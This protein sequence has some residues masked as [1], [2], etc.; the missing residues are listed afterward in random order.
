MR[1]TTCDRARFLRA[2]AIVCVLAAAH[3]RDLSAQAPPVPTAPAQ[4]GP[5]VRRLTLEE[6]RQLALQ[7][8]Q[9]LM[10]ARLNVVEKGHATAAA[11]KDYLPKVLGAD[12]FFHF[13]DD[14]GSVVTF[15]TGARGILPVSARTIN[16]AVLNQDTNLATLFVAQP[17]TKLIAVHAATQVARADEGAAQAQLDKGTRDVLSGVTQAFH[18]L[19]G[20]QRIQ[21]ALE[22]QI[23]LLEQV[24]GTKPAP[25]LR[26][27]LLEARQGLVQV[28]GQVRELTQQFN[29]LLDLPACTVLDLIDPVP[30]ELSIHREEDA[31]R[32]ALACSPEVREAEQSIAKAEAAMKIAKM[33]CLPDVSVVAGYANQT[34]ASY[35]QPNIGYVGVTGSYTFWEWGKR[36]DIK[37]QRDMDI[38]LAHQNVRVV[39][40]KVQLDARK[41]YSAYDQSREELHLA[42]EMVQTRKEIAKAATGPAAAQAQAD[43]AKAELEYMKAEIAYRVAHAQLAGLIGGQ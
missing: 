40:D 26:V 25:Q 36:R 34:G 21:A 31:A 17:I 33:A 28:R 10:L 16:A 3:R 30:T 20:A 29:D 2:L 11:R 19:L 1:P 39:S 13:N 12:T 18:G 35:I 22:L 7:Q 9:S 23:R 43:A 42:G 14:L 24:L 38:A 41:A 15:Q 27:G 4:A 32:Q 8:N 6:A 5:A 37:R